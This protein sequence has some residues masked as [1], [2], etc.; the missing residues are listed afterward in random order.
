[1]A[2]P[3][4]VEVD[5]IDVG[6]EILVV[7][8]RMLPE[9]AL[10]DAALA[11]PQPYLRAP[12]ASGQA[13]GENRLD[14]APAGREVRIALRQRP[15]AVEVIGEDDP[16]VDRE[17]VAAAGDTNGV[18][19]Q[20]DTP[21]E[22]VVAAPL[23]QVDGEEIASAGDTVATVVGNGAFPTVVV[24]AG[25]LRPGDAIGSAPSSPPWRGRRVTLRFRPALRRL[26][27]FSRSFA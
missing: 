24:Y 10:P 5:V 27:G 11:A 12:L 13:T 22:E 2:V 15:N 3:D 26:R 4:R 21:N 18:P 20:V 9:P 1:M 14:Q 8:D 17:R 19:E 7:A 6:R 23:E 25:L 16:G